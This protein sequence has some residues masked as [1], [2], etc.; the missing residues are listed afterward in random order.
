VGLASF[1]VIFFHDQYGLARV[2]AGNFTALCVF[3][4]S[5]LRPVGGY[6]ADRLGGTRML[7][8]LFACASVGLI[9]VGMLPPLWLVTTLL[10]IVMAMLGMGNGSVFQLVP[11][12][13]REEI[14]VATGVVGAAGGLGG[15]LLPS[16][17][18]LLKDLTGSYGVG[19]F[20]FG[21]AG[22]GCLALLRLVQRG[23][24]MSWLSRTIEAIR[25]SPQLAWSA[26]PGDD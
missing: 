20:Y 3:A 16:F 12:R 17:L 4:G 26:R 18:G 5:F 9:A 25:L 19:F 22:L 13:F 14:G 21:L 6:L 24:R 1:L 15:F 2:M 23:W 8:A 10:F 7:T 11:Q